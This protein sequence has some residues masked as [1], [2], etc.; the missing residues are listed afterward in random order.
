MHHSADK[1][2]HELDHS[3]KMKSG[4]IGDPNMYL[5]AK[6]RKVVLEKVVQ[7]WDTSE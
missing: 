3:F 5:G 6:M 7:A 4:S 1:T 2:L